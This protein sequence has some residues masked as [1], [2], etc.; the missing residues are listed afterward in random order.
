MIL[1]H[2]KVGPELFYRLGKRFN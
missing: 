1:N 2:N